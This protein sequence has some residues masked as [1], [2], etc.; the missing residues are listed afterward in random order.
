M[1]RFKTYYPA[2]EITANLYTAGSEWMTTNNVVYIGSYHRYTTGEVYTKSTWNARTSVKLIPYIA[3]DSVVKKNETYIK[4]KPNFQLK[5]KSPIEIPV[6]ITATDIKNKYIN[7]YFLKKINNSKIIEVDKTQYRDW[8]S[9]NI[10][11]TIYL[12]AEMQWFISGN[13]EDTII[14]TIYMPGVLN[15]NQENTKFI[16]MKIPELKLYLSNPLEFYTDS[17]FIVPIDINGLDS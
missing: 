17:D 3:P 15:I 8:Q 5:R 4:L 16:A 1:A 14:G 6:R 10:D 13:I 7:R 12:G 2:D 9:D 11:K